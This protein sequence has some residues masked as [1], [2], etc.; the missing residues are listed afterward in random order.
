VNYGE[1][2]R[3]RQSVM[4]GFFSSLPSHVESD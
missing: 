1:F 4:T 2:T 3:L